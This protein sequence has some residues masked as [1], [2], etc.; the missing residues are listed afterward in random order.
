MHC[1]SFGPLSLATERATDSTSAA[2]I[3]AGMVI[4]AQ[5]PTPASI[6]AG[7]AIE[8]GEERQDASLGLLKGA[9]FLSDP[10]ITY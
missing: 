10:R 4:K 9:Y 3:L 5:S 2:S 8:A 6:L 1:F 7:L